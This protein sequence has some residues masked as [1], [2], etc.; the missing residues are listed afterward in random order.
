MF[1]RQFARKFIF[2]SYDFNK[3][4]YRND[5]ISIYLLNIQ[6]ANIN[7]QLSLSNHVGNIANKYIHSCIHSKA[8]LFDR[9]LTH[10][11]TQTSIVIT[12]LLNMYKIKWILLLSFAKSTHC[13][14][15]HKNNI[16]QIKDT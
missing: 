12:N 7:R 14:S 15:A 3:A 6:K 2:G 9:K 8:F 11:H 1:T 16:Q 5:S 13:T 4:V 10:T